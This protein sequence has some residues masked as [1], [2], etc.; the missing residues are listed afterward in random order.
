MTQGQGSNAPGK[1]PLL[2][3]V[4]LPTL[5]EGDAQSALPRPASGFRAADAAFLA[6][7]LACR[8]GAPAYRRHRRAEPTQ[9][10]GLYRAASACGTGPIPAPRTVRSA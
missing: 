5:H 8:A 2:P 9:A 4:V 7:L 6:Q 10:A 3:V 1:L